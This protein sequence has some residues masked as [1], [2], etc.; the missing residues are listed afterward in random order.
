MQGRERPCAPETMQEWNGFSLTA[1][2]YRS[3]TYKQ[4]TGQ[5]RPRLRDEGGLGISSV[6]NHYV[7]EESLFRFVNRPGPSQ[8]HIDGQR[9]RGPSNALYFSFILK[10]EKPKRFGS[11][12]SSKA[13]K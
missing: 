13:E 7:G 4:T 12:E 5:K 2:I 11:Q 3:Y 10:F 1:K 9:Q 6:Y 8:Y